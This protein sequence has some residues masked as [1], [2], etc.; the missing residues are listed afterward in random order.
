[1]R[2][3]PPPTAPPPEIVPEMPLP[4]AVREFVFDADV[5]GQAVLIAGGVRVVVLP[6]ERGRSRSAVR[7]GID[8]PADVTVRKA[9]PSG[10]PPAG[11]SPSTA[12]TADGDLVGM[13]RTRLLQEVAS[14]R[15]ALRRHRRQNPA[16]RRLD[17]QLYALLPD[18]DDRP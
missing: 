8:A 18:A 17:E 4:A 15:S 1:M 13:N 16:R 3:M 10:R 14:L 12:D 5:A 6:P 2:P 11:A 7:I 9:A